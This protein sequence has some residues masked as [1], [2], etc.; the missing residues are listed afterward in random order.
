MMKGG[1]NKS[2]FARFSTN[3]D[4][5]TPLNEDALPAMPSWDT[6]TSVHV[7]D[8]SEESK[9]MELNQINSSTGSKVPLLTAAATTG[10]NSPLNQGNDL[11]PFQT[12]SLSNNNN[13]FVNSNDSHQ[14]RVLENPISQYPRSPYSENMIREN[15]A[16][17]GGS[18]SPLSGRGYGPPLQNQYL[19]SGRSTPVQAPYPEDG[20]STHPYNQTRF[21][22][23]I[24]GGRTQAREYGQ[25]PQLQRPEIGYQGYRA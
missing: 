4:N 5:F 7:L 22:S 13:G 23:S 17:Y 1:I 11:T 3:K 8:D 14:R 21:G 9:G 10:R 2:Q 25:P 6:A 18:S 16:R 19:D 24:S 15:G 20:R 12:R